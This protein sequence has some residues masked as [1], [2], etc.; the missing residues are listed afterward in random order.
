MRPP[1]SSGSLGAKSKVPIGL[2]SRG[3]VSLED[4]GSLRQV[5]EGSGETPGLPRWAARGLL[6]LDRAAS[7]LRPVPAAAFRSGEEP[8]QLCK[9]DRLLRANSQGPQNR[10]LR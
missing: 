3:K 9:E 4:L 1:S 8:L 6:V 5:H 7:H 2:C 10:R